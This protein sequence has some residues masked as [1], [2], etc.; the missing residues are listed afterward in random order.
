MAIY[1]YYCAECKTTFEER[2]PMSRSSEAV[3]C[4]SGHHAER[5]I[6]N[7]AFSAGVS[8]MEIGTNDEPFSGGGCACGGACACAG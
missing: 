8:T 1:E 4:G 7:F 6:T 3:N 2:R 5:T